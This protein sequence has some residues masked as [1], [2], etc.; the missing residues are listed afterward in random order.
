ML[1]RP[2][3]DVAFTP[4]GKAAQQERGSRPLYRRM[5]E[6]EGW[7][8]TV[9]PE[10]AAFSAERDSLYLATASAD[11]QPYIQHRRGPK[12]FLR[13]ID[14]TTIAFVDFAGNR[15][16]VTAGNLAENDRAFLF[17]MTTRVGDGS[18]F[19]ATPVALR[20]TQG[21]SRTDAAGVHGASRARDRVRDRCVGRQL[22]PTHSA[23]A[24]RGRKSLRP[25]SC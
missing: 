22:S 12:G 2:A 16:Y 1:K 13:M 4:S 18:R 11:G 21:S 9:T 6:G 23:K 10:L 19:G 7:E 14:E 8:T 20:A 25:S 17:L 3:S 5:E 15:Q 24:G